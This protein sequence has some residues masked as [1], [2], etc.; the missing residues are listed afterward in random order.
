MLAQRER[1]RGG[2]FLKPND[3][4]KQSLPHSGEGH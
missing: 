2:Y 4:M 1:E 3:V